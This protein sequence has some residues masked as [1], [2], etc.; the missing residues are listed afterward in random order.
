M[1]TKKNVW[2][3]VTELCSAVLARRCFKKI[4]RIRCDTSISIPT[5][6][7]ASEI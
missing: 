2:I 5:L 3:N 4:V 6:K 1:T 7:R